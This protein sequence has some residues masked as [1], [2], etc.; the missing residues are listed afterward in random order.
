MTRDAVINVLLTPV[1]LAE[2]RCEIS[3]ATYHHL[4]RVRRL[5]MGERLRLVDGAGRARWGEIE[6]I[7]R[8]AA[9]VRLGEEAPSG[10]PHQR[11]EIFVAPPKP[12]RA[13]WLVEKATELG[14]TAV[15]F[16]AAEREA[17]RC[18]AGQLDRLRRVAAAAVEQC[19]RSRLPQVTGAHAMSEIAAL[20]EPLCHRWLLDP[21]GGAPTEQLVETSGLAV[22]VGPEGGFTLAERER[23]AALGAMPISFG[24]RVLRVETAVVAACALAASLALR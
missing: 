19:G 6:R 9:V 12:E 14:A 16:L 18:A 3:G 4:F 13:A 15:R 23:L 21:A 11:L 17:R 7:A 22:F 20:V 24:P 8:A 2:E 5:A 1:E 10:E